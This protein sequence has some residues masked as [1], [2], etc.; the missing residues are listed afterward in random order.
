MSRAPG[1]HLS[2]TLRFD[3]AAQIAVDL[4]IEAGAWTCLLGPSGV[5]KSTLLRT[6]AGL[7]S[8]GTFEGQIKGLDTPRQ[9]Q[10]AY[11]AQ[12]DGLAPWLDVLQNVTLGAKLRGERLDMPRAQAL[13]AQVGLAD[14]ARKTPS[15][16]S[17]GM[18]QRA[19][20]A[21][22]LMEDRQIVLLDEPFSALDAKNRAEMQEL[23]FAALAG[24]TVLLVT[25]D[26][27][28]AVRLGHHILVMHQGTIRHSALP[29]GAPLRNYNAPEVLSAGAALL[30]E[31][32]GP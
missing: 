1:L 27:S 17:G 12:D 26:P 16:L 25:H 32:R 21:R 2:G 28:E 24:R 9:T 30:A 18:R 10:V 23:A 8:G 11:M 13:V 31:L 22:T 19:A 14:H 6:I 3:A 7:P 15:A 29:P 5:G 4:N 20:L